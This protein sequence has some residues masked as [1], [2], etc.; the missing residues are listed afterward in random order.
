VQWQ[1]GMK[2]ALPLVCL[3][4]HGQTAWTISHQHTGV[5]DLPLTATGEAEAV[6][7]GAR[8]AGRSFAAVFTSPLRRA[9]RTCELA[10]YGPFAAVEPDLIEWN[11]G[12]YEGRTTSDIDAER[13]GWNLFRDGCPGGEMP[14]AV[15]A[16]ADRV[17]RRVR[18]MD[19]DVLIF[20]SAHF[21]RV[22]AAR[23]LGLEPRAGKYFVLGT[24]SLSEMGFEHDRSEPVIRLWDETH[25][26]SCV[27]RQ[28]ARK[29]KTA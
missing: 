14:E 5:T 9:V 12:A 29:R 2:S 16:R 6:H 18:A 22:F 3:A 17:I 7:L 11:Y 1:R 10:G 15:G 8:L 13:D 27:A 26:D 23:W 4:R 28:Q 25:H 21:L 24:A 20:S 19:G